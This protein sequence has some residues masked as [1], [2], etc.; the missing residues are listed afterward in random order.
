MTVPAALA[1]QG[2]ARIET[3]LQPDQRVSLPKGLIVRFLGREL[4]EKLT[5][6]ARQQQAEAPPEPPRRRY[7]IS[8]EGQD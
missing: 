4:M 1:R 5:E 8:P 3:N 6:H 2:L 7:L